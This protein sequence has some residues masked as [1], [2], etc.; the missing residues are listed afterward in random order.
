MTKLIPRNVSYSYKSGRLLTDLSCEALI[1]EATESYEVDCPGL[2]ENEPE[3]P[4]EGLPVEDEWPDISNPIP[5]FARSFSCWE[6]L[7]DYWADEMG[8]EQGVVRNVASVI[9]VN[10][11]ILNNYG[12]GLL[13]DD[14]SIIT[15]DWKSN[16]QLKDI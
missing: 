1:E 5:D 10:T 13:G 2:A 3:Q 9:G 7:N 15:Q 12:Y 6:V 4:Q 16:V 8:Y 14:Y 11:E